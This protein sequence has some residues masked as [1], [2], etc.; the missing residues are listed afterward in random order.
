MLNKLLKMPKFEVS[1]S[2][3]ISL[4]L[5]SYIQPSLAMDRNGAIF[6]C[7]EKFLTAYTTTKKSIF[8]Q[9]YFEIFAG[10]KSYLPAES[11]EQ[12][13]GTKPNKITVHR[14]EKKRSLTYYQWTSFPF[15]LNSEVEIVILLAHDVTAILEAAIR[16]QLLLDSLIDSIPVEI[17]WKDRD[18]VFLGCN[19]GFVNSLGLRDKKDVIGRTDFD[20]PVKFED[21]DIFRADDLSII[22]SKVGRLNIEEV[23]RLKENEE[24][25]LLTSK[26][27]LFDDRG[28]VY[29]VLGVY[30]DITKQKKTE[31][32]LKKAIADA[33]QANYAKS[34]FIANMSHDIRTP[35]SGVV[36]MSQIL[37]D[38]LTDPDHKQ[39]AKWIHESGVQLLGL[40]NDILTIIVADSSTEKGEKDYQVFSLRQCVEDIIQLEK[41]STSMKGIFLDVAIDDDI[42]D[43]LIG[44]R[45]SLYRVLLN[46][47]GN[48]IK[49]TSVG[50]VKI[51]IKKFTKKSEKI[52]LQFKIVDTGIGIPKELQTKVFDRFYKVNPSYKGVYSGHGIGLH[53]AQ[54]YV[55]SL[56]GDLNFTSEV[57]AGTTFY[58]NLAFD[59]AVDVNIRSL[60]KEKMSVK[61]SQATL[62]TSEET[63]L[64]IILLIEDNYVALKVLE[65]IVKLVGLKFVSANDGESALEIATSQNFKLIITDIGLPGISGNEFT[66]RIRD[67]EKQHGKR[68]V[69]IIGLTAHARSQ[70]RDECL[71]AGMNDTYSKPMDVG[72]LKEIINRFM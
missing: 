32:A 52:E 23:Q 45:S 64:P 3:Q 10:N 28:D 53:I 37:V 59:I 38:M 72:T 7:N 13:L 21:S 55:K 19:K 9:N 43:Y 48:A 70:I 61:K 47:L 30:R 65:S 12:L 16:E 27:P 69:P 36:G 33:K 15:H 46:L 49:F 18:L 1:F 14:S 26:V 2:E 54:S 62:P 34:E 68:P 11:I 40:L 8:K 41:P 31:N 67:W 42:P 57:G 4:L 6:D 56:G 50:F 5:N 29:G 39:R 44:D 25:I 60:I 66:L 58:F 71:Q 24:R 17:F 63:S 20:L 22:N 35:L 51:E